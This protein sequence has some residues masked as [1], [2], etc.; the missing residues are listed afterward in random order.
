MLGSR[1]IDAFWFDSSETHLP[2][3]KRTHFNTRFLTN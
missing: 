3:D 1:D 2:P